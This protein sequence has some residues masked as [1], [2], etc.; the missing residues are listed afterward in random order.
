MLYCCRVSAGAGLYSGAWSKLQADGCSPM[1][2]Q[3]FDLEE[4]RRER[5]HYLA[6]LIQKIWRGWY[7]RQ[8]FLKMKAAQV[9]ISARFRGYWVSLQ[10]NVAGCTGNLF[11]YWE[12]KTYT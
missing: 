5:M 1:L 8:Q 9:V 11:L 6:T 3:L 10:T 2:L 4:R 7:L 12:K